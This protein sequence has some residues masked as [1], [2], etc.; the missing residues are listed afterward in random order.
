MPHYEQ[1]L[2]GK[3]AAGLLIPPDPG[4]GRPTR[5]L[6][7]RSHPSRSPRAVALRRNSGQTFSSPLGAVF[8]ASRACGRPCARTAG[9]GS[10]GWTGGRRDDLGQLG[11][12]GS[13]SGAGGRARHLRRALHR[14]HVPAATP[15]I[16]REGC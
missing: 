10:C 4:P 7:Y 1:S 3:A 12:R 2:Q 5:E 6:S 13:S 14:G 15:W 9:E 11:D 16:S 8:R